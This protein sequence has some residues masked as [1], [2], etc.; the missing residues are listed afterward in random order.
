MVVG[1][2]AHG[3]MQVLAEVGPVDLVVRAGG[4]FGKGL[5]ETDPAG[6]AG[7]MLSGSVLAGLNRH[8]VLRWCGVE[9][10]STSSI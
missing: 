10:S 9:L 7:G 4:N 6:S 5:S 2:P 1:P 3:S 8:D